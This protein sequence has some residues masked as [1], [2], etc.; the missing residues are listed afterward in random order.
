[1]APDRTTSSCRRLSLRHRQLRE[2]TGTRRRCRGR[3]ASLL[4]R[5]GDLKDRQ[6]DRR[7][8]CRDAVLHL[9]CRPSIDG[10]GKCDR[11]LLVEQPDPRDRV[12]DRARPARFHGRR[13]PREHQPELHHRR[14]EQHRASRSLAPTSTSTTTT[15]SSHAPRSTAARSS[16]TSSRTE[17]ARRS[18]DRLPSTA[19]SQRRRRRASR[20]GR[21]T[22]T[23]S[24]SRSTATS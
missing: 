11:P 14:G 16:A 21:R 2:R 18:T 20:V 6:R 9:R 24:S 1:M 5:H 8:W 19:D 7:R 17:T 22:W 15:G 3:R 4:E 13:D 12:H 10:R 23:R